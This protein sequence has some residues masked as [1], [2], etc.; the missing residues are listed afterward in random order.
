M[1]AKPI[2]GAL[3]AL[4]LLSVVA[5]PAA[6]APGAADGPTAQVDDC[7]N[8]ENG[9]DGEGPPGFVGGL[10][11]DFV[12]GLLADLPVPN[13]VKATFGAETC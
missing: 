2:V 6:A 5:M 11:P 7:K 9:P 13:F 12:S 4:L 3:A 10:V 8:A 1:N